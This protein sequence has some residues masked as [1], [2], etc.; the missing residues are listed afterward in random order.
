M[1]KLLLA[2]LLAFPAIAS[3][4]TADGDAPTAPAVPAPSASAPSPPP[5]PAPAPSAPTPAPAAAAIPPITPVP[6]ELVMRCHTVRHDLAARALELQDAA[7]QR[8]LAAMPDCAAT[9]DAVAMMTAVDRADAAL[10]ASRGPS[11]STVEVGAGVGVLSVPGNSLT[12]VG[13]GLGAGSFVTPRV[14]LTLRASGVVVNGDGISFL[15]VGLVGPHVQAWVA[16]SVWLGFGVGL[17]V[18][19]GCGETCNASFGF[20][21]DARAGFQFSRG[22]SVSVELTTEPDSTQ[23]FSASLGFQVR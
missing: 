1:T 18:A 22:G 7:R 4:Q 23:V 10:A 17:A 12:G 21:V 13:L 2:A 19:A 16:D 9:V 8:L 3:A 20:G 11:T 5:M 15:Y 14:A 6:V